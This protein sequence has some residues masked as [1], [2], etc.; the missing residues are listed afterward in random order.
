MTVIVFAGPTIEAAAVRSLLPAE[1]RPPVAF[2]D[3][4][5]ACKDRP[6][7]LVIIDG[8]FERTAAVWHKEILWAMSQGV[9]VFGGSS[10]G[11]L[12]AAEL[13][14]FG[15][16]GVGDIFAGFVSGELE[17]DDE[18]AV[19]HHRET[20]DFVPTSDALVDIRATLRA[21]HTHGAICASSAATLERLA[22]SRFYPERSFA[23]MVADAKGMLDGPELAAFVAWLPR[24][25]V[26][27][28]R[29]DAEA[30]LA[31][32]AAWTAQPFS[33][34]RLGER[35]NATD[36]WHQAVRVFEQRSTPDSRDGALDAIVEELKLDGSYPTAWPA[37]ALR[38]FCVRE[39]EI[40]G[41][42]PDHESMRAAAMELRRRLR[43]E[44]PEEFANW[45]VAENVSLDELARL[46]ADEARVTQST[47]LVN[48]YARRYLVDH[49][50]VTGTYR[51]L[52]AHA[53]Q[54][55]A[56]AH[57]PWSRRHEESL[58]AISSADLWSWYFKHRLRREQPSD[59]DAYARSVGFQDAAA[60]KAAVVRDFRQRG[61]Q[62]E[63]TPR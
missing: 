9:H 6:R 1:V 13:A 57:E 17:D 32:V 24:G 35:F 2:G 7:A 52:A 36:A 44:T 58:V 41:T 40:G 30:T 14:A 37:A 18:V 48:E 49:L 25:R 29:K 39:S 20:E 60:L 3:V 8:V 23:A 46:V 22:K 61:A 34:K 26:A 11:A 45:R 16:V 59:L 55:Q 10:M 31:A 19:A 42:R 53:A 56:H 4:Y 47:P 5:R 12:R 21:A 62:A 54:K 63:E 28:K 50:R 33:P 38:G 43:L 27:L 15:M 51:E